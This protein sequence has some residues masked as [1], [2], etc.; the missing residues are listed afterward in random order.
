MPS[1]C[2]ISQIS[3]S[4]TDLCP[5]LQASVFRCRPTSLWGCLAGNSDALSFPAL[6]ALPSGSWPLPLPLAQA[7][8][9]LQPSWFSS[10]SRIFRPDSQEV[11]SAPPSTV[12]RIWPLLP[13]HGCHHGLSHCCLPWRLLQSPPPWLLASVLAPCRVVPHTHLVKSHHVPPLLRTLEPLSP[14]SE[15]ATALTMT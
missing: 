15:G 14:L 9:A 4:C 2:D 1:L 13:F 12:A 5:D 10:S 6:T 7:R 8:G 11:L 3:I